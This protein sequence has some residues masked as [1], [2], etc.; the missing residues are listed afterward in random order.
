[1]IDDYFETQDVTV[2]PNDLR[3]EGKFPE[4]TDWTHVAQRFPL[5]DRQVLE[6]KS[7]RSDNTE[8]Y[9]RQAQVRLQNRLLRMF[10]LWLTLVRRIKRLAIKSIIITD[11]IST[12]LMPSP[13]P[14]VICLE[15]HGPAR[16]HG[17]INPGTN[18]GQH[19]AREDA[20]EPQSRL[21]GSGP[22]TV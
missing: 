18:P 10:R 3:I 11:L 21:T 15:C 2:R 9:P 6:L 20:R 5:S 22:N 19:R 14:F 12:V 16:G 1:M 17:S 13:K 7:V 8:K 4:F